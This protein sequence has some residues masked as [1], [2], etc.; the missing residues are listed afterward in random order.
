MR[1]PLHL[2]LLISPIYL[3][4]PMQLFKKSY[5]RHVMLSI[6]T[7]LGNSKPQLLLDVEKEIWKTLFSLASGTIDPFDLL[8]Q[9]SDTLPWNDIHAA[10]ST[11][12]QW[13]NLSL[14]SSAR[15]EP[16][17]LS[18]TLPDIP[19]ASPFES[20]LASA[21]NRAA[22]PSLPS[23]SGGTVA[24]SDVWSQSNSNADDGHS[25][26]D[27][28]QG[29]PQDHT[30]PTLV[31]DD[32]MANSMDADGGLRG[33]DERQG[34]P[35]DRTGP[36]LVND[37]AMDT[38]FDG[39]PDGRDT[40]QSGS[41]THADAI[42]A[43]ASKG[44]VVVDSDGETESSGSD[45]ETESSGSDGRD[46]MD[47]KLDKSEKAATPSPAK[48]PRKRPRLQTTPES[49]D[50]ADLPSE[51]KQGTRTN[52]IDVDL[53]FSMWEP[54]TLNDFVSIFYWSFNWISLFAR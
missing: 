38:N 33:L 8:R 36:A 43:H 19:E 15:I 3:L 11:D 16:L 21:I 40:D 10:S 20:S 25:G 30:D 48:R 1:A 13:F 4:L 41:A 46:D 9:L 32:V 27:E 22:D 28:Q 7:C 37:D 12:S 5:N 18:A 34:E 39:E 45:G 26:S 52:P 35:Q 17:D 42:D 50:G 53:H 47:T 49:D 44:L 29:E 31:N 6:S 54:T 51:S 14:A 23:S 24:P 2:A